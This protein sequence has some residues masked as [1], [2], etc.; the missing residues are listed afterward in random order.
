MVK[1]TL[2]LTMYGQVHFTTHN[3]WSSPL[4]YSQCMVK[5]TLLLTM[6]GQ[7]HFTTH[8]VWSSI[9]HVPEPYIFHTSY[10]FDPF[11]NIMYQLYLLT[12]V[13]LLCELMYDQ[14]QNKS[15]YMLGWPAE[16]L[17]EFRILH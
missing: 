2:P 4:Y 16:G 1:S 7:V 15:G 3:V 6:Y 10:D 5:S 8:N 12:Q 14:P 17:Y 11:Y 13:I 9:E